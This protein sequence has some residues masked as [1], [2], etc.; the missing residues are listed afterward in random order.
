MASQDKVLLRVQDLAK[1]FTLTRGGREA[2]GWEVGTLPV[3]QG[4]SFEVRRGETLAVVG[5]LGSGKS[6]LA[7]LVLHLIPPTSGKVFFDGRPLAE[8]RGGALLEVRHRAQIVFQDPYTTLSPRLTVG[9]IISEPMEVHRLHAGPARA[10]KL[11]E[12]L[13]LVGLNSFYESRSPLDFSGAQRQRVSVARALSLSPEF[14]VWDE[15]GSRLEP[16]AAWGLLQLLI[17]MRERLG[18]TCLVLTSSAEEA[19]ALGDRVVFLREGR[20][21]EVASSF[22]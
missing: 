2:R 7:R 13:E 8:L 19:R 22:G 16:A 18:L 6:T 10:Q 3:I 14:L 17:E 12:L 1:H 5:G 15:P 21:T 4:V 11:T 9:R 20:I